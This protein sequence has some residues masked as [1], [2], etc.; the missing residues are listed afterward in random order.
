MREE[1]QEALVRDFPHLCR[2]WRG[3]P[4]KTCM[5]RGFAVGDGW[6]PV[7][8]RLLKSLEDGRQ[9]LLE[10][11]HESNRKVAEGLVLA[12]VKE[13]FGLLR[14]YVDVTWNTAWD[15]CEHAEWASG[16][17]C[18]ECGTTKNVETKGGWIKTLCHECRGKR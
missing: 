11:G 6:E 9:R 15:L 3:D 1:L 10:S 16:L 8:R 2:D 17:I 4:T 7:V 12:Q 5:S 13:K 18:E 14:V